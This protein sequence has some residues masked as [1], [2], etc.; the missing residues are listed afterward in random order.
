MKLKKLIKLPGKI[1]CLNGLCSPFEEGYN[2]ARTEDEEIEIEVSIEEI[3]IVMEKL[4][5]KQLQSIHKTVE[6]KGLMN[7]GWGD[8]E[9]NGGSLDFNV[10][11][12]A[13]AKDIKQWLKVKI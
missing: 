5:F 8:I 2:Q 7:T 6:E 13:I 4:A 1:K 12:D 11:A 3:V 9:K 10:I